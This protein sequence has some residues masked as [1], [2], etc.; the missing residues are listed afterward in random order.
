M[1]EDRERVFRIAL[2]AVLLAAVEQGLNIDTL[3][4]AAIESM[5][6]DETYM[7]ED[8]AQAVIA[9]EVAADAVV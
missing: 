7:P 5:L 9:I 3:S 2:R 6:N 8:V 1:S 4:E